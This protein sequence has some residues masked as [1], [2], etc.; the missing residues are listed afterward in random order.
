[1]SLTKGSLWLFKFV[2]DEFVTPLPPSCNAKFLG[3]WAENVGRVRRSRHP[4]FLL[5][6]LPAI[7]QGCKP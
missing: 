6:L 4:A 3:T 1:M 2:P 5:P 7:R